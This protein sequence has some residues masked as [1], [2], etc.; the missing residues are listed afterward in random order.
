MDWLN[1]EILLFGIICALGITVIVYGI[2]TG[3]KIR[4]NQDI[5]ESQPSQDPESNTTTRST[6]PTEGL[7]SVVVIE[8][9]RSILREKTLSVGAHESFKKRVQEVKEIREERRHKDERRRQQVALRIARLIIDEFQD[10][11]LPLTQD[12]L[13]LRATVERT[14]EER[15][16]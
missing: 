3:K 9:R 8:A 4:R 1:A 6:E 16:S 7:E 13:T 12:A 2:W 14:T 11:D 10:E 5:H 15:R